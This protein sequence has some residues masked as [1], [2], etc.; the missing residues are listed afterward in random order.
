MKRNQI[1]KGEVS[2]SGTLLVTVKK[3]GLLPISVLSGFLY[4]YNQNK[5]FSISNI[6]L[7]V[8]I[9]ILLYGIFVWGYKN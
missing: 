1:I 7:S 8:F 6:A 9:S 5:E 4:M 3:Y 2:K